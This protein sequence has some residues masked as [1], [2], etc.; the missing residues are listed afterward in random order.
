MAYENFKKCLTENGYSEPTKE[1]YEL[2][3]ANVQ[4]ANMGQ[5]ERKMFL[6]NCIHETGGLKE[7]K[8]IEP[9]EEN[10]Y[11]GRGYIQLTHDYNYKILSQYIFGSPNFLKK[12]PEL[13]SDIDWISW[14]TATG[15]WVFAVRE[16]TQKFETIEDFFK[17]IKAINPNETPDCPEF[18]HRVMIYEKL[19]LFGDI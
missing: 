8:E 10:L 15:Y 4:K 3:L 9:I 17:T 11:F 7:K 5:K 18:K 1:C 2:F 19:L 13:V 16:M 12:R 6:A 14:K